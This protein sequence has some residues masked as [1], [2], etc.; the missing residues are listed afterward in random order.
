M[1]NSQAAAEKRIPPAALG[2]ALPA[3]LC[4]GPAPPNPLDLGSGLPNTQ[5]SPAPLC[6]LGTL[7]LSLEMEWAPRKADPRCVRGSTSF[8]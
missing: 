8:F 6:K 7:R 1:C 3:S 2:T 4:P 5:Q